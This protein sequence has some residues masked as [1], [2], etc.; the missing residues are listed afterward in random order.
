GNLDGEMVYLCRE[1]KLLFTGD[2]YANLKDLIPEREEFN[3][4]APFF[5]TNVNE[6]PARLDSTRKQLGK[7]MD[8]V[9]R[10]DMIVCGD[11]GNIKKL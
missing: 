11:H 8:A 10:D 4:I 2:I 1:H 3:G 6:D 5:L 9:G 7:I